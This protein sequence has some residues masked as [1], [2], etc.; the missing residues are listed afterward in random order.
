MREIQLVNLVIVGLL[1]Y[2]FY[3]YKWTIK[4]FLEV[5][6]KNSKFCLD[7]ENT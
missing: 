5:E 3:V 4:F 2:S 7:W 1:S 6:Q